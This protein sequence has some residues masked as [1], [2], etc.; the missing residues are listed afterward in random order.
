MRKS[1]QWRKS[2]CWLVE[3]ISDCES[4]WNGPW[5]K[6]SVSIKLTEL[7]QIIYVVKSSFHFRLKN[8]STI[9]KNIWII[10]IILVLLRPPT[11]KIIT[12]MF[13]SR[14]AKDESN[15]M[16]PC[17]QRIHLEYLGFMVV[18]L[19]KESAKFDSIFRDIMDEK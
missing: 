7:V 10:Q 2:M 8:T 12:E 1:S 3:M 15:M 16:I 11:R 19:D 6:Q 17:T 4:K 18:Y 5:R 9:Y 13:I 14:M